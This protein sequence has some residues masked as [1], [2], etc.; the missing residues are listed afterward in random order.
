MTVE[1]AFP[2][3]S[4]PCPCCQFSLNKLSGDIFEC[5]NKHKFQLELNKELDK[6]ILVVLQGCKDHSEGD[7]YIIDAVVVSK[8]WLDELK[9]ILKG[10]K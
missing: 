4:Y 7:I 5:K 1:R 3:Y 9:S 8:I 6:R 2:D 10:N